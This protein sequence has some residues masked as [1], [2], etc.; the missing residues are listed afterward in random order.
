MSYFIRK[1]EEPDVDRVFDLICELA[2]YEKGLHEVTNTKERLRTDCFGKSPVCGFY[3]ATS[4][5]T[6][7]GMAL[8]YTSYSTWVGRC[9]YLEDLVVSQKFRGQGIGK[10]LFDRILQHAKDGGFGRLDWQ[11]LNWNTPAINFYKKHDAQFL[12]D[13]L[14]CRLNYEQLQ[15]IEVK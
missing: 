13:W 5:E 6:I 11:V 3:I 7:V 8:Y 15:K 1:G 12:N 10:A 14:P 9:L 4:G 2:E